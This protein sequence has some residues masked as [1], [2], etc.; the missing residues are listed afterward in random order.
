MSAVKPSEIDDFVGQSISAL[1]P[2]GKDAQRT[3]V[4]C[5]RSSVAVVASADA[6][7]LGLTIGLTLTGALLAELEHL[8]A[9]EKARAA[10][11]R[12]VNSRPYSR[13]RL[14]DRLRA[15]GFESPVIDAVI[16]RLT[17]AGLLN[18]TEYGRELIRQTRAARPAGERLLRAKLGQHGLDR[19]LIDQLVAQAMADAPD[20]MDD[21][22]VDRLV[23]RKA[24]AMG[25]LDSATQARR[26]FGLLARRG[27][28]AEDARRIVDRH[29]RMDD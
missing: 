29:V 6:D 9:V 20:P 27:F 13:K 14:A 23:E 7:R 16:E 26:L 8:S 24:A 1:T 19:M 11:L 3:S 21:P 28:S 25:H 18:D 15:R 22:D 10:A 2:V 17:K 4:R 12:L 5:G